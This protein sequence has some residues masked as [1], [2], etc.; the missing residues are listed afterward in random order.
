M[1]DDSGR[2]GGGLGAVLLHAGWPAGAAPL[3]GTDA[4]A[5]AGLDWIAAGGD[6]DGW[7]APGSAVPPGT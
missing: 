3:P 2:S 7:A 1:Q 5:D 4:N 6:D